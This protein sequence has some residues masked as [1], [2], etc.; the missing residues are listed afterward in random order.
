MTPK[1][2]LA[3]PALETEAEKWLATV[4]AARAADVNPFSGSLTLMVEP[5]LSSAARWYVTAELAEIDSLAARSAKSIRALC[6]S[7][8]ILRPLAQPSKPAAYA[9]LLSGRGHAK[10]PARAG[11]E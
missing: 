1:N 9:L 3:S 5:R 7:A 6:S 11:P 4:A 2:L 10:G 8:A